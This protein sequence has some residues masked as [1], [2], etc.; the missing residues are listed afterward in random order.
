MG[1]I[2]FLSLIYLIF[3]LNANAEIV[4]PKFITKQALNN[5][6]FISL[7][8]K[9]TFSQKKNGILTFSTKYKSQD[10]LTKKPNTEFNIN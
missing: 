5:L 1:L 4:L 3:T 2:K 9:I 8:G 10:I 6:R 7:D